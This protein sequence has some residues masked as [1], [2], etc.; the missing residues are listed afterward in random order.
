MTFGVLLDWL[1]KHRFYLDEA[2]CILVNDLEA[3]IR[4][5]LPRPQVEPGV[6]YIIGPP[7]VGSF[8]PDPGLDDDHLIN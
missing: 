8:I 2:A 6:G 4:R 7:L 5:A 3:Q 1:V